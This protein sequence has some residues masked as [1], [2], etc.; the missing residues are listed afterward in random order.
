MTQVHSGLVN[1]YSLAPQPVDHAHGHHG[2]ASASGAHYHQQG[3]G[4]VQQGYAHHNGYAHPPPQ[5]QQQQHPQQQQQPQQS[6]YTTNNGTPIT[7]TNFFAQNGA[8]GVGHP[9]ALQSP[10][11][12]TPQ[13]AD[14]RS[15]PSGMFTRNLIGSLSASAFKLFDTEDRLG[16]WFILQDL[17]VRTEGCFR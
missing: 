1:T 5:Q 14:P 10:Q 3:Q 9:G 4:Q 7:P 15:M 16:I 13:P 2:Q 12:M 6:Y 17:S 8:P 11:H